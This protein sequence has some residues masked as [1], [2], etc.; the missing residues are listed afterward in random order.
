MFILKKMMVCFF[1]TGKGW[2]GGISEMFNDLIGIMIWK[3]C[4]SN[5][6]IFVKDRS[7]NQNM[8]ET[9]TQ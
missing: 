7:E 3:L 1:F 2:G 6:S 4:S 5:W 8:F 9:T